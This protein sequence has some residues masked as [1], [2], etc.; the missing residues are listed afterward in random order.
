MSLHLLDLYFD[1]TEGFAEH[2]AL[3]RHWPSHSG[4]HGRIYGSGV[5]RLRQSKF[6]SIELPNSNTQI[7]YSATVQRDHKSINNASFLSECSTAEGTEG[8]NIACG[9][10]VGTIG[11]LGNGTGAGGVEYILCGTCWCCCCC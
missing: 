1:G 9:A 5:Q 3:L 7:Y 10:E 4:C 2:L 6:G 11:K 8:M